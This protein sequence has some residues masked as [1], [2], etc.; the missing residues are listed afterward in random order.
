GINGSHGFLFH[1]AIIA[2][3]QYY[4]KAEISYTLSRSEEMCVHGEYV[5]P[6]LLHFSITVVIL[7]NN[8]RYVLLA[9]P[10]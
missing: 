8:P 5:S 9:I 3:N 4:S 6:H 7:R 10:V 1:G 2:P